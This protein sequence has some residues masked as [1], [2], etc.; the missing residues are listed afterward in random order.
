M[1]IKRT[2]RKKFSYE[3]LKKINLFKSFSIDKIEL[4][5]QRIKIKKI[6]NGKNLITQGEEGTRFY[7]IKSGKVDIFVKKN[8]IRTMNENEYLGERALFFKEPRSATATAK[9]DVEV[10]FLEKEDFIQVIEQNLKEY[11]LSRLYLQDNTVQ[12]NDLVFYNILGT[13]NYGQVCLVKSK[14]N[15]YYYA[16]KNI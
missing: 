6:P 3:S 13:G 10:F 1:F 9:G 2:I 8:Y 15:N 14:K 4:L 7:I 12:L 16:I 5:S 11:L